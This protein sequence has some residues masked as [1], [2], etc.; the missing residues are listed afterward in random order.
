MMAATL[1]IMVRTF[2]NRHSAT[3]TQH[4]RPAYATGQPTACADGG[5]LGELHAPRERAVLRRQR[6][7]GALRGAQRVGAVQVRHKPSN[8][9]ELGLALASMLS[10]YRAVVEANKMLDLINTPSRRVSRKWAFQCP[11]FLGD[12]RSYHR[13]ANEDITVGSWMVGLDVEY[14]DERRMCCASADECATR[15]S[16]VRCTAEGCAAAPPGLL[17]RSRSAAGAV[18]RQLRAPINGA[19]AETIIEHAGQP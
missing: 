12:S 8:S 18:R 3:D 7:G 6:P 9:H 2:S 4:M 1:S 5:R 10:Q 13:Y 16:A 19:T 15:V 11:V 14:V 17:E